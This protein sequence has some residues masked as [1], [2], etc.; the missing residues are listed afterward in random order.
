VEPDSSALRLPRLGVPQ[1]AYE[2]RDGDGRLFA[3]HARFQRQGRK[4]F[5]WWRNGAW[6]LGGLP[7]A[8]APLWGSERLLTSLPGQPVYVTEGEK[9]AA[10]LV[11][12]GALALGTVTGAA[13]TPG[14]TP[15]SVL[16]GRRV[17]LWPD[18]DDVGR[19]HMARIA[20]LLEG[21]CKIK[22][23]ATGSRSDGFDAADFVEACSG[24]LAHHELPE[25]VEVLWVD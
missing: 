23:V 10:A 8:A 25:H 9:A 17:I 21:R 20:A 14:E 22:T 18:A 2:V 13:G 3:V 11:A 24:R 4:L 16:H 7:V 12:A 6:N 1:R 19:A 15:L 5:R